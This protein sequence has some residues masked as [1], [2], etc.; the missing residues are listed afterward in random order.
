[1]RVL[2]FSDAAFVRAG[3]G[4]RFVAEKLTLD[5]V[6][7]HGAAIDGN[8]VVGASGTVLVDITGQGI[9]PRTGLT[10]QQD[11]GGDIQ[12]RV[13]GRHHFLHTG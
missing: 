7:G 13:D 12:H 3:K 4:T 9:L 8:E 1:M 6:L 11:I 5:Q 2:D 10:V